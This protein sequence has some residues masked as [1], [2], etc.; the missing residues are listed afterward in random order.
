MS[1]K[2]ALICIAIIFVCICL[3]VFTFRKSWLLDALYPLFAGFWL[4]D[5]LG[6]FYNWLI[7]KEEGAE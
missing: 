1:K 3:L 6:D 4:G 2:K 7:K 5:K